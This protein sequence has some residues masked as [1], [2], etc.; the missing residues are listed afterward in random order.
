MEELK[1]ALMEKS[2]SAP[3]WLESGFK[4]RNDTT[5]RT[6]FDIL[7]IAD[8]TV[9]SMTELV[10]S[11]TKYSARIQNRVQ[12]GSVYAPYV[13]QQTAAMKVFENGEKLLLPWDL[14]YDAIHG[15]SLHEKSLLN[16]ARPTSVGQAQRIE[17]MTSS[18][19]LRLL[20]YVQK[21]RRAAAK[22]VA[23][24]EVATKRSAVVV[25]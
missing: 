20:A 15:L 16:V 13:E 22:A 21:E 17:G 23:F 2:M 19:T 5:R 11:I 9:S 8:A 6:V 10:P 18:G 12:I 3:Q 4:V 24:E 7:R 1:A 14:E 25:E